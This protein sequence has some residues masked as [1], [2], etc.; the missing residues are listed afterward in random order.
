MDPFRALRRWREFLTVSNIA[1][2]TQQK[3]LN[4]IIRFAALTLIDPLQ[5]TEDNLLEYL[6]QI[7]P[8]R[9]ADALRA[10]KSL[11]RFWEDREVLVDPTRRFRVPRPRYEQARHL[12]PDELQR[13]AVAAAWRD[14]RRGLAIV[15]CYAS[16]ARLTSLCHVAEKDLHDTQLEFRVTKGNRP[17]RVTLGPVGIE[18][19]R[20]LV[21]LGP[22]KRGTLLGVVPGTFWL[23]VHQAGRD[24][25]LDVHPHLLRHTFAQ[26]TADKCRTVTDQRVWQEQMGHADLSQL[27]RYVRGNEE[28]KAEVAI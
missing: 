17:Y 13:L 28:R 25:G 4:E 24:A 23:W 3:Y 1:D 20:Q 11:Y 15:L 7:S 10:F 14:V 26:E 8:N 27:P 5:A 21:A 2:S 12:E 19:F 16:G 22:T 18:A 9:R 6:A